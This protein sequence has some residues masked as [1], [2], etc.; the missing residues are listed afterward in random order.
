[1]IKI[2]QTRYHARV[3]ETEEHD[4]DRPNEARAAP[5]RRERFRVVARKPA[6]QDELDSFWDNV[7][8]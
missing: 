6:V 5:L 3:S 8:L 7:P 4:A 2:H 1:M